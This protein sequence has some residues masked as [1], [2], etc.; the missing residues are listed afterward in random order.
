MRRSGI[1]L[2]LLLLVG[3]CGQSKLPADVLSRSEYQRLKAADRSV[4]QMADLEQVI[5]SCQHLTRSRYAACLQKGFSKQAKTIVA[6]AGVYTQAA[7]SIKG[8]CQK[9][10]LQ[11]GHTLRRLASR[12]ETIGSSLVEQDNQKFTQAL[13][14]LKQDVQQIR[15]TEQTFTC[16]HQV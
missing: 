9:E 5:S 13:K 12:L 3:G 15:K 16:K 6:A 2:I 4:K 7:N 10:L 11:E 1:A 14:A 8:G